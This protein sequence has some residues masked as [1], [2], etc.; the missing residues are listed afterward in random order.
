MKRYKMKR[1]YVLSNFLENTVG[2]PGSK[3]IDKRASKRKNKR[4]CSQK[5]TK[6]SPVLPRANG[7]DRVLFQV[8]RYCLKNL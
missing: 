2:K 6:G 4:V 7:L 3:Q 1:T 8:K 5:N